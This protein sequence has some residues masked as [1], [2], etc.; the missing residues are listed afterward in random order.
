MPGVPGARGGPVRR[1]IPLWA[2][3]SP[4]PNQPGKLTQTS[5]AE[6]IKNDAAYVCGEPDTHG[7]TGGRWQAD[8]QAM[9]EKPEGPA[10]VPNRH[11]E[12]PAAYL[13]SR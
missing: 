2:P 12:H 10:S 5:N 9:D 11:S 13:T 1:R 6:R 7:L 3:E 4:S 8:T